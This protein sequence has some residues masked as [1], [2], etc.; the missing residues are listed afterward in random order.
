MISILQ[1]IFLLFF[2]A[3][4]TI[5]AHGQNLVPNPGFED[6]NNCPVNL[7]MSTSTT[8]FPTVKDWL[9]PN[10]G[11]ADYFNTCATTDPWTRVPDHAL[12][13]RWPH[14][15]NGYAGCYMYS[16]QR[17][18]NSPSGKEYV[19]CHLL[20]PL[21]QGCL[22]NITFY[23]NLAVSHNINSDANKVNVALDG[24]GANVSKGRPNNGGSFILQV[25]PQVRNPK[26]AHIA[27]TANWTKISGCFI[28]DGG[29]EWLT[30]GD[31]TPNVEQD[32]RYVFGFPNPPEPVLLDTMS[33]Y[34]IDDVSLTQQTFTP[35]SKD[36]FVCD[37]V[38]T[39]T[40]TAT[41]GAVSYE[42]NTGA[43]TKSISV[44]KPGIYWVKG[45]FTGCGDF[46]DTITISTRDVLDLPDTLHYCA[47]G[48]P[49][50]YSIRGHYNS[51]AWLPFGGAPTFVSITPG[52][53]TLTVTDECGAQTDTMQVIEDA[54]PAPPLVNDTTVCIHS[55]ITHLPVAGDSLKWYTTMQSAPDSALPYINTDTISIRTIFVSQS[56]QGCESEKVPVNIT[57]GN[58]FHIQLPHDTSFCNGD[59]GLIG[60][61]LDEP[62]RYLWNTGAVTP[63]IRPGQ[64]GAYIL[65]ISNGCG[66]QQ[67]TINVSI[68]SDCRHCMI[69]P[70]AFTPNGDG[71][72]DGLGPI[73]TCGSYLYFFRFEVF[74]RWGQRVFETNDP[75]QKWNG[76]YKGVMQPVGN[77][78]YQLK[79]ATH[80]GE[81]DMHITNEND[82][83]LLKGVFT[84]VR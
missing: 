84:L 15:G 46:T 8:V 78:F 2:F 24:V 16:G 9:W 32:F 22:Y 48:K 65:K 67:D 62:A 44:A 40:I 54:K 47:G 12:G 52:T 10:S 79:Y 58:D 38:F 64:R 74:N 77:Y 5:I 42:W 26:G 73:N 4:S 82:Y 35:A 72:N 39:K 59:V 81:P 6:Y 19:Q 41:D 7:T 1:R 14:S 68:V 3:C 21:Q 29:E 76:K 37:T 13:Y 66:E 49:I 20:Q 36:T 11:T 56:V 34:Y 51:Y 53:Y 25:K 69:V 23:V 33:Y 71:L 80:F 27:D 61:V 31:F 83:T 75:S 70:D 60:Y 50:V 28:A 43:T 57:I 17:T 63:F 30:I 18:V 45:Y 55:V